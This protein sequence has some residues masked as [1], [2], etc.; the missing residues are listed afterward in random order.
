MDAA[1]VVQDCDS[2]ELEESDLEAIADR[3]TRLFVTT[4]S[5]VVRQTSV[6]YIS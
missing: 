4:S 1:E 2:A 5:A 3:S 6:V